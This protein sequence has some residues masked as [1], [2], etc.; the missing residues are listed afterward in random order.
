MNAKP[1]IFNAQRSALDLPVAFKRGY[2][3]RGKIQST[4]H[5]YYDESYR[6]ISFVIVP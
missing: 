1:S 2:P 3:E 4:T 5:D 6:N